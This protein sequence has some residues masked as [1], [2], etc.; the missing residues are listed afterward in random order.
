MRHRIV[1]ARSFLRQ[2]QKEEWRELWRLEKWKLSAFGKTLEKGTSYIYGN[3]CYNIPRNA[4]QGHLNILHLI[5][6]ICCAVFWQFVRAI[7]RDLS[8]LK[9]MY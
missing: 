8:R 1:C 4:A 3:K 6:L 9:Q 5:L 2:K 7:S